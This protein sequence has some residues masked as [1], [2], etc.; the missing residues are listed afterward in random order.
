[1]IARDVT[2]QYK[3]IIKFD[4]IKYNLHIL[5]VQYIALTHFSGSALG[6]ARAITPLK[7]RSLHLGSNSPYYRQWLRMEADLK[8]I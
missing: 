6:S 5:G 8:N 1:M 4:M 3:K 2:I 7:R